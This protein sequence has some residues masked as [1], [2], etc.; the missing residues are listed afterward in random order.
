MLTAPAGKATYCEHCVQ[1]TL[2]RPLLAMLEAG[3]FVDHGRQRHL[4]AAVSPR[5]LLPL[6]ERNM[7]TCIKAAPTQHTAVPSMI[8]ATTGAAAPWERHLLR[9]YV[10]QRALRL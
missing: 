1:V 4:R 7:M 5:V 6:F 10:D 9:L 2:R 3:V 8:K